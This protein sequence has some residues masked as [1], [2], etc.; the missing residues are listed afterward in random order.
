M[1][2][3]NWGTQGGLQDQA[4]SLL[5]SFLSLATSYS[6]SRLLGN[7]GDQQSWSLMYNLF[8][9]KMLGLNFVP[10]SVSFQLT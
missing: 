6:G 9:D 5:N 2:R 3:E 7:Y 8:A 10:Q 1:F 4:S